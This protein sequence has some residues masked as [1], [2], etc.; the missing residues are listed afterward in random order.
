VE[1]FVPF[2][3]ERSARGNKRGG[4]SHRGYRGSAN[5][6]TRASRTIQKVNNERSTFSVM[7]INSHRTAEVDT[8]VID[9][10]VAI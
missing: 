2:V 7:D 3:P 8:Q 5:V 1:D 4:T 10:T 9:T 6:S